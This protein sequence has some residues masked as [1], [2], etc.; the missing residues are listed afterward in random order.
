MD[1][2]IRSGLSFGLTSAIITTLGL[3]IGLNSATSSTMVVIG[4]I[5][6]IAVADGLSDSLGMHIS[7]ESNKKNSKTSLL[8]ITLATFFT[9]LIFALT[10]LIPIMFFELQT[11]ITINVFYGLTLLTILS[12]KIAKNNKENPLHTIVE[13]LAIAIGVLIVSNYIGITVATIFI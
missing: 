12:Y 11:A 6:T 1:P 13:H 4:G 8:K 2:S 9:K 5:I 7:A 10:F 3:M